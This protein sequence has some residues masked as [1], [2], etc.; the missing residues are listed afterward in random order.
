MPDSILGCISGPSVNIWFMH[1]VFNLFKS[2]ALGPRFNADWLLVY[3]PYIHNNRNQLVKDFLSTDRE[4]L[5]MIDNDIVFKPEDV[6]ALYKVANEKGPG[7]YSAGYLL[8]DGCLVCGVWDKDIEMT[9]HPLMA[10]PSEPREIGVV[11]AGFT[12]IHRNVFEKI[13]GNWFSAL[14]PQLGEDLSF[15]WKAR[16]IGYTPWLVPA[17]NPGHFKTVVLYPHEQVRNMVGEEVNL[18]QTN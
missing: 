16:E 5:F 7:V 15:S 14:V 13:D 9:Y 1:S 2:E 3:G 17:A 11:G 8:E 18:V 12:L 10:L 6:E 4:W